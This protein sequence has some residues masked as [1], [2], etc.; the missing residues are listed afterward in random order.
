PVGPR[1]VRGGARARDAARPAR[2]VEEAAAVRT[3]D[4][5]AQREVMDFGGRD[6]LPAWSAAMSRSE[7]S[8]DPVFAGDSELA[9]LARG[10]DWASTPLGP[11]ATW[12]HSL[13][14]AVRIL[15]TSRFAMWMGWGPE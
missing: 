10:F 14:T 2:D 4:H 11:A 15:L 13:R 5:A 3:G 7:E 9:Q 6:V 8:P 12:P 1:D